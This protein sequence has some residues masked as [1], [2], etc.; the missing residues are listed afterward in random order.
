MVRR[1]LE[2]TGM[3]ASLP[4]FPDV[5]LALRGS[6]ARPVL[7]AGRQ[8]NTPAGSDTRVVGR[9]NAQYAAPTPTEV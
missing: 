7:P 8:M 4:T 9:S 2:V 3:S 6:R 5:E 1:M